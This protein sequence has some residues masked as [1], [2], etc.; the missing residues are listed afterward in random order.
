VGIRV[1]LTDDQVLTRMGLRALLEDSREIEIVGEAASGREALA[2]AR[3]T[4]PDVVVMDVKMSDGDGI[5]ATR[6]I[7]EHCPK[8]QVLIVSGYG[9]PGLLRRAATAGAAGFVLKDISPTDL[10]VAITAVH[11]GKT[12]LGSGITR[13]LL[14]HLAEN[15]TLTEPAHRGSFGLTEREI[16]VL[17]EVASGLS[18]KEIARK[19]YLSEST[20][21]SHLRAIY[22]R[23]KVRNRAHAAVFAIERN[24]VNS[25]QLGGF[26]YSKVQ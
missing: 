12:T 4:N 25:D 21:K 9:D 15:G 24:L 1:L 18:D 16:E 17:T 13:Q 14:D 11:E 3:E 6:T 22:R 7:R 5:E 8:T 20:V 2:M 10:T 26:S 23:L 19:L